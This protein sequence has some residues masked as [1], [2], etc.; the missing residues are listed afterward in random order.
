MLSY[1]FM[2]LHDWELNEAE[3]AHIEFKP[4]H[5]NIGNAQEVAKCSN[6]VLRFPFTWQLHYI[7][8]NEQ[9]GT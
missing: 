3:F 5:P 6:E 4:C 1:E 8:S 2:I 7:P 9:Q